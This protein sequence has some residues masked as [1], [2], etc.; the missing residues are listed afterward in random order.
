MRI[1]PIECHSKVA[2]L[3]LTNRWSKLYKKIASLPNYIVRYDGKDFDSHG[4]A[5]PCESTT[6]HWWEEIDAEG[7]PTE[8][9]S[10]FTCPF[11]AVTDFLWV[12]EP[13]IAIDGQ[14]S[15]AAEWL[16]PTTMVQNDLLQIIEAIGW[17]SAS[18]LKLS[19]ARMLLKIKGLEVIN[20]NNIWLWELTVVRV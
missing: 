14:L 13:W 11:G 10:E 15:F 2:H 12:Q 19:Q 16:S 20:I 4:F 7:R 3:L 8:N 1:N 6:K 18:T 5:V 17:R 9:Y